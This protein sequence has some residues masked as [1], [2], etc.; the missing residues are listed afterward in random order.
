MLRMKIKMQTSTE[1]LI[2]STCRWCYLDRAEPVRT[3]S[4]CPFGQLH[5]RQM[6]VLKQEELGFLDEDVHTWRKDE[7]DWVRM[8]MESVRTQFRSG[9]FM[10]SL[11]NA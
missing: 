9:R 1:T 2:V 4:R 3:S 5:M 11:V 10:E 8:E 6:V 7:I